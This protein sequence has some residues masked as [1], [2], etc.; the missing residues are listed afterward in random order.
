MNNEKT[1]LQLYPNPFAL[2][3]TLTIPAETNLDASEVFI[4]DVF[5]KQV[6]VISKPA[7]YAVEIGRKGLPPGIY[8]IRL[9]SGGREN[10]SVKMIVE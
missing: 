6:R 10:G 8:F 3:A 5:G 2:N 7:Q 1:G 9:V 4:Y